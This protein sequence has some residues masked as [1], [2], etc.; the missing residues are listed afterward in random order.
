M[1]H[2]LPCQILS[3][4]SEICYIQVHYNEGLLYN[5]MLPEK[6]VNLG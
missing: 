1:N 4:I 6:Y 5:E 2:L 3:I